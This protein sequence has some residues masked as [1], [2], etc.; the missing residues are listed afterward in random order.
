MSGRLPEGGHCLFCLLEGDK[1]LK[2]A[3]FCAAPPPMGQR[4]TVL[5]WIR[6]RSLP[7]ERGRTRRRRLGLSLSLRCLRPARDL[8]LGGLDLS[9]ESRHQLVPIKGPNSTRVGTPAAHAASH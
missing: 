8:A 1:R 9:L 4:Y 6:R 2:P 3:A 7:C 5:A